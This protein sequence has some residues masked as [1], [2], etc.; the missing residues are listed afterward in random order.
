LAPA[1][2]PGTTLLRIRLPD[3]SSHQRRFMVADP[4]QAVYDFVDSLEAVAALRYSLATTFPRRVYG[5]G[6]LAQSLQELDLTPQAVLLMQ[7]EDD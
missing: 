7:P 2:T 4:L 1:G 3:G 5:Q 6:C